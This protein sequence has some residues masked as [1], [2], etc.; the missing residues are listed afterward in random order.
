[1]IWFYRWLVKRRDATVRYFFIIKFIIIFFHQRRVSTDPLNTSTKSDSI[2]T[3]SPSS[4]LSVYSNVYQ[5]FLSI[6][7]DDD[8]VHSSFQQFKIN[9]I[10][11]AE[12]SRSHINDSVREDFL[13]DLRVNGD[14]CGRHG[15]K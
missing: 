6:E 12:P 10:F 2:S 7:D 9:R 5:G 3:W 14:V 4:S 1:M 15:K 8:D 11:A 13:A